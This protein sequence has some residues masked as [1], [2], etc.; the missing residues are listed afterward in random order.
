MKSFARQLFGE[1]HKLFARKRTWLGF[2]A[3]LAAECVLLWVLNRPQSREQFRQLIE[4]RGLSFQRYYSGPTLAL[5]LITWTS[6]V[7]GSL[8]L[9][10][11]SADV[12]SGEIEDGTLRTVLCRPVS[13]IRLVAAKYTACVAW[14]FALALFLA[15]SA[16]IAGV[17]YCGVGPLF[18]S[19]PP[20]QLF[21]VHEA[22]AGLARYCAAIPF[23]ALSFTA[24]SSIGFM[25]SCLKMKPA[26]A[27]I[28]TLSIV[29]VD[30]T[31]RRVPFFESLL[32][33]FLSTHMAAWLQLFAA[34][35]PWAQI[36]RDCAYL[37]EGNAI[38]FL[39]ALLVFQR[40]D[41]KA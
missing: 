29:L 9:A 24:V 17:L 30:S 10:L 19:S 18:V 13:R 21:A 7:L 35:I 26:A 15:A 41:F 36:G 6:V 39:V 20:D 14:A 11:V 5:D 23:L 22:K 12:M 28:S 8:F 4:Q 3:I 34:R 33:F 2:G 32:P 16:L 1:L 37:C 38:C 40:R 25:F 31:F 27:T